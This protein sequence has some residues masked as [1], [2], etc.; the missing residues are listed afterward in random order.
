MNARL[1]A[2]GLCLFFTSGVRA[3]CAGGT[4]RPRAA[5]LPQ[6]CCDDDDECYKAP[7][8]TILG[9]TVFRLR[10]FKATT[11]LG[12][13]CLRY[14][15]AHKRSRSLKTRGWVLGPQL[16]APKRTALFRLAGSSMCA[17]HAELVAI[18]VGGTAVSKETTRERRAVARVQ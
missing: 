1:L 7:S 11:A 10:R 18:C 12:R 9:L 6:A 13:I 3:C 8:T 17:M 14:V 4:H 16:V 2:S 5:L 15:H